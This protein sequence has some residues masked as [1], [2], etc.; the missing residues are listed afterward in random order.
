MTKVYNF[1]AKQ[2][3]MNYLHQRANFSS[4]KTPC[5]VEKLLQL[6]VWNSPHY[7][8]LVIYSANNNLVKLQCFGVANLEF[9][10]FHALVEQTAAR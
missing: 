2:L 10:Q 9:V 5:H 6:W 4:K 1:C 7:F 8:R 3:C